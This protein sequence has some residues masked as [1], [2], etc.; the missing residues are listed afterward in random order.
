MQRGAVLA[1]RVDY[2]TVM[3]HSGR[4]NVSLVVYAKLSVPKA[5]QNAT[6]AVRS[7]EQFA[8]RSIAPPI[9]NAKPEQSQSANMRRTRNGLGSARTPGAGQILNSLATKS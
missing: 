5:F 4:G 2:N 3:P 6:G 9:E 8:A 1:W 7:I